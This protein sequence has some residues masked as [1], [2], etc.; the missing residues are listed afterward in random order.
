M[1]KML[2]VRYAVATVLS[3]AAWFLLPFDP[4]IRKALV[5]LFF[6]PI[7]SAVPGFTAELKGDVGLSSAMNSLAILISIVIIVA[8]LLVMA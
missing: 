1:V 8:L 6:S 3:L 5:I 2:S 4:A 7:G